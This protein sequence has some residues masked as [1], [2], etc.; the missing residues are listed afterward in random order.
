MKFQ[1]VIACAFV[2]LVCTV[3]SANVTYSYVGN[4]FDQFGQG[5][6]CPPVCNVE[7]SFTVAQPLAP[8][9]PEFSPVTPI[10]MTLDSGGVLLTLANVAQY[11]ITV[12]TDGSGNI[13]YFSLF[14]YG[15][16]GTARIVAQYT[17]MA[18]GT[19]DDIHYIDANGK[20]GP[21]AGIVR[22]NPGTW[23]VVNTPEPSS[24][25][26]LGSAVLGAITRIRPLL[27]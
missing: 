6:Q 26:L 2:V 3:A 22:D 25:L 23:S 19:F 14:M 24:L 15:D 16:P 11:H 1:G 20:L 27:S 5:Y 9:L 18:G 4:P 13:G 10:S 12:S 17:S 21:I 8:N 7:A